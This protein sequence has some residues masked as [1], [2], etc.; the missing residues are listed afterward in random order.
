MAVTGVKVSQLNE[1]SNPTSDDYVLAV[2]NATQA[3]KKVT[4]AKVVTA[5][6]STGTGDL[7]R[8]DSPTITGHMVVPT[9]TSATDPVT[10][11]YA[12]ALAQGLNVKL[13]VRVATTANITLSGAQTIDGVSVIA[14]DRVL[15]K[16]QSTGA[17]NGIYVA[18][19]GAWSRATDADISAEVTAGMFTFVTEG[20]VS[21]NIGYVLTTPNP[22]ILASTALTFTQFSGAGT[23]VAGHGQTSRVFLNLQ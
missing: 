21:A 17:N 12:D 4:M 1:D 22:I 16:N 20:T 23:I 11:A 5:S 3:S 7:V 9:P 19:S 18:A 14:G 6:P 13:S 15:A 2:D 10:K 8:A